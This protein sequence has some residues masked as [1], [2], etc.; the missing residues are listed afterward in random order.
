[1]NSTAG[2]ER[3]SDRLLADFLDAYGIQSIH[4]S[5]DADIRDDEVSLVDIRFDS[6]GDSYRVSF[7]LL[8]GAAARIHR[9]LK[10]MG[11][12][13]ALELT[14][15]GGAAGAQAIDK[16]IPAFVDSI[17][18]RVE[19]VHREQSILG[20]QPVGKTFVLYGKT[21]FEVLSDNGKGRLA[22]RI[23]RKEGDTEAGLNAN[24]LLDGLYSGVITRV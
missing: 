14:P 12:G 7:K 20:I 9:Y 2:S 13:P 22:I 18:D 17:T 23:M 16:M 15:E 3:S 19:K 6:G 1:M 21:R 24:D 10:A 8:A 4:V 11:P 5:R